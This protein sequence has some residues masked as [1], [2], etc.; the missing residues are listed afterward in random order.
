MSRAIAFCVLLF[1]ACAVA[2][3]PNYAVSSEPYLTSGLFTNPLI[4]RAGQEVTITVRAVCAGGASQKPAARI[5]ILNAAGQV[6]FEKQL[7]LRPSPAVEGDEQ[8]KDAPPSAEAAVTWTSDHNG[9]F[10]V[11]AIVDPDNAVAEAD[12]SDNAAELVLPVTVAGKGRQPH[13]PWYSEVAGTRWCTCITSSKDPKRLLERGVTPLAWEYG[14]MSWSYYDKERAKT[15]PDA[16]IAEFEDLF[17]KKYTSPADVCGFGIDEVGGYPETFALRASVASMKALA[18]AKAEMPGRFFAVWSGGGLRPE[19]AAYCRKGADLL[20]LETYLW[21]ALPDEIGCQDIYAALESRVEPYVRGMDMFQPAYGNHCYTLFALDMSER[22]DRTDLG[23]LEQVI[24]FIRHKYPEMR[25]VGWYNAGYGGYGLT[26]TEETDRH[27][28][29][30]QHKAD[31]L[32]F[33]YWIKPCVTLMEKSLWLSEQPD[34]GKSLVLAVNN[35]GGMDSGEVAVELFADG[36]SLGPQ[37]IDRVPAGTGRN[38]NIVKI[39][40]PIK[41]GAGPHTFKALI[42]S[43]PGATVLDDSVEL[44]RYVP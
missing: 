36:A 27:H 41:T 14:G 30:V 3:A 19:I 13:F 6:S 21:R 31:E 7:R 28:K 2:A 16:V 10:T 44:A 38:E 37:R 4:P 33:E 15:D 9:L 18:R 24:R 8:K 43:A 42:I 23:E 32:C 40:Q 22:P 25:G 34:G 29:A 11:R 20:L 1:A 12:E 39:R 17:Y 26:R 35:I 5:E